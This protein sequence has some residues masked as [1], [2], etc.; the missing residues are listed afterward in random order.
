MLLFNDL[1]YKMKQIPSTHTKV[2]CKIISI[3]GIKGMG[4]QHPFKVK[5]IKPHFRM[6]ITVTLII[7]S[8]WKFLLL[9]S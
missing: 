9:I 3:L 4:R 5:K 6:G 2:L 7:Y 8:S 1:L